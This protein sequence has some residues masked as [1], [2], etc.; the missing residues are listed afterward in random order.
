MKIVLATGIFPPEIGGPAQY[1]RSVARELTARGDEVVVITYGKKPGFDQSE[2]YWVI[3]V[4]MQG[5]SLRRW[6]RYREELAF[7]GSKANYV[8]AFTSISAGV[9]MLMSGLRGPQKIL[10]LGGDFFWER[11]TDHGGVMTLR[12]WYESRFGF[13]RMLNTLV[14]GRVLRSFDRLVYSTAFQKDI[15]QKAYRRL[16]PSVV[17]PNA[18][19]ESV[20]T[21]HERHTPFRLLFMGRLVRF[22][23]ISSL[24][25]AMEKLP[26]ALLTIIGEGPLEQELRDRVARKGL[27]E[28]IS[29][30]PSVFGD[31]KRRAFDEHDLLVLPSFTEISPNTA[32]EARAA[33]LPVLL[34][35]E[36]GLPDISD[37]VVRRLRHPHEIAVAV[38][39]IMMQ[40]RSP[41]ANDTIRTYRKISDALFPTVTR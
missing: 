5:G 40:Y 37:I 11:F 25:D 39:E 1:V 17:E 7:F 10:R 36:T 29:F 41:K 20:P 33:C 12:E 30:R 3:S 6:L 2:G 15:H 16:P 32:L 38:R 24:I 19:P 14:M 9:P 35:E 13:W 22:K 4:G 27:G 26:D 23:N 34:T 18:R 31:D 21:V 28:Q 8:C